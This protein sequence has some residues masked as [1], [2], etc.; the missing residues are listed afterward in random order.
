MVKQIS[1]LYDTFSYPETQLIYKTI[2]C[3]SLF[4]ILKTIMI[5]MSLYGGKVC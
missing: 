3:T 1:G 2:G 4:I 5:C